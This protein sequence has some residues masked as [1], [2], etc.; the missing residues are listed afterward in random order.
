MQQLHPLSSNSRT[1]LPVIKNSNY[2]KVA[3]ATLCTVK[4]ILLQLKVRQGVRGITKVGWWTVGFV[5]LAIWE[6]WGF[7]NIKNIQAISYYQYVLK[8]IL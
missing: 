5:A 2:G 4:V 7:Y 1:V 3:E 8:I 6:V